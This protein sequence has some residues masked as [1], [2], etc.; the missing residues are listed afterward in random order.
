MILRELVKDEKHPH[1]EQLEVANSSRQFGFL[2]SLIEAALAMEQAWLSQTV[3]K[4]LNFHAIACLHDY[5]GEYRPCKVLLGDGEDDHRPPPPHAVPAQMD[6][7][8]NSVNVRW[9][10]TDALRLAA[11][12]LWRL[13]YIHPFINGNGRTARAAAYFVICLKSGG[14]LP[15]VKTLPELICENRDDYVAALKSADR[16]H[17]MGPKLM[18]DDLADLLRRLL[19]QQLRSAGS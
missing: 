17:E 3:I 18:L 8:V 9:G 13:N 5:A 16:S 12:V 10:S 19:D 2:L 14:P 6:Q 11:F 7:F 1:Y 4:A 15:G